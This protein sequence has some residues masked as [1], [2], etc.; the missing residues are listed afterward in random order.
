M[1]RKIRGEI[2]E[3]FVDQIGV[4]YD[5][6]LFVQNHGFLDNKHAQERGHIKIRTAICSNLTHPEPGKQYHPKNGELLEAG[7]YYV[8]KER[9]HSREDGSVVVAIPSE[10]VSDAEYYPVHPRGSHDAAIQNIREAYYKIADAEA[11]LVRSMPDQLMALATVKDDLL[12][13]R[14][15]INARKASG[16][17]EARWRTGLE[18]EYPA[19]LFPRIHELIEADNYWRNRIE[20]N[21]KG[22]STDSENKSTSPSRT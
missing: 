10:V 2:D 19:G 15:S 20:T 17:A 4:R 22:D 3:L 21:E 12:T 16:A 1:Q 7:E 13:V 8:L 14:H 6:S 11:K 18:E 9:N 5:T